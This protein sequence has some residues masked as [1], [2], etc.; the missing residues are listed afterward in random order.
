VV[1]PRRAIAL[2]AVPSAHAAQAAPE[3]PADR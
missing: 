3:T 1:R 2:F